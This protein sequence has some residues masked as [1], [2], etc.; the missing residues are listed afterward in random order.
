MVW[1][2]IEGT[3]DKRFF[4]NILSDELKSKYGH[5]E[6]WEYAR[7]TKDK[8]K[9]FIASLNA[10]NATFI[11]VADKDEHLT[12]YARESEIRTKFGIENNIVI[13]VTE[14]ES[15]YLAGIK[16]DICTFKLNSNK[17]IP[18]DTQSVTKETF[19]SY[20][21]RANAMEVK[22]VIDECYDIELAKNRN[23]SFKEFYDN[24][25]A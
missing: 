7:K 25:V 8:I 11:F 22:L 9:G 2:L 17:S 1:L 18:T 19:E 20:F 21:E 4:K 3:D 13:V 5:V 10:M 23:S 16:S 24:F 12:A 6:Y 14:I 15:W